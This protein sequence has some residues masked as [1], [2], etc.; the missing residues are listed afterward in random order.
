[1]AASPFAGS[2][3]TTMSAVAAA[4]RFAAPLMREPGTSAASSAAFAR[5]RSGSREPITISCPAWAQRTA[6]PAPSLPVPPSM[7]IFMDLA[8][9]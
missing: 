5:A 3:I 9:M 6:S 4:S 7:P 8:S 2:A 1:V